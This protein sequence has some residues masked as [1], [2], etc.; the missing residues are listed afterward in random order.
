MAVTLAILGPLGVAVGSGGRVA[1]AVAVAAWVAMVVMVGIGV[2]VGN[3]VGVFDGFG[4]AVGRGV[5]VADG[6]KVAVGEAVREGVA[7]DVD[8]SVTVTAANSPVPATIGVA[9]MPTRAS[10]VPSWYGSVGNVFPAVSSPNPRLMI[11]IPKKASRRRPTTPQTQIGRSRMCVHGVLLA[12]PE[13]TSTAVIPVGDGGTSGSVGDCVFVWALG[14]SSVFA[15]RAFGSD[16]RAL[17]SGTFKGVA[18]AAPA[19]VA[20]GLL[21]AATSARSRASD[22]ASP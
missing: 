8:V 5:V 20:V 16:V 10:T 13:T 3:S 14:R 12:V 21:F 17:A 7:A 2:L 15:V 6:E 1:S 4:V 11:T 22:I 19:S 9:C 18:I